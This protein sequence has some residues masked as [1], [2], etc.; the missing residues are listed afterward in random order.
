[1]RVLCRRTVGRVLDLEVGI[2][3]RTTL[4][5]CT[6]ALTAKHMGFVTQWYP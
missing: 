5:L 3:S 6:E 1:M 2:R 4:A